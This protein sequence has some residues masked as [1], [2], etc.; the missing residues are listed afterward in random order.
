MEQKTL[1]NTYRLIKKVSEGDMNAK[2]KLIEDNMGL[3]Y[4]IAKKFL[5]RG[6][7]FDDLVQIGS[8]GL[9]N[10]INK[11]DESYNVMFS[12]YAVPLIM[13][14]IKR[15]LRDDGIIKASRSYRVLSLKAALM[16]EKLMKVLGREPTINEISKEIGVASEE[17]AT[18]FEATQVPESIYKTVDDSEKVLL[19]DKISGGVDNEDKIVN[20]IAL[21]EMIN[22]L[23][24]RE[25]KIIILRYFKD[26]KQ[27]EIAELL[28]IS[29]V[30]V[31]RLEKQIL[32]KIRDKII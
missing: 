27:T 11:F 29:Q 23:L 26:K 18:A 5:N 19:I 1:Q 10:A 17:I 12:T 3:V 25:R 7:E 6:I 14:E 15:F 8:I 24:P 21:T 28:G 13:G 31:S 32:K 4:S 9:L 30:Q 16:R 20:K 2:E 22:K